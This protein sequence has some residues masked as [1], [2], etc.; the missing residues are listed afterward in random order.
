MKGT[1]VL[2]DGALWPTDEKTRDILAKFNRGQILIIEVNKDRNPQYHRLAF[3]RLRILY[4]MVDTDLEFNPWRRWLTVQAGYYTS[5]GK[6]NLQGVTS[7]AL[8]PDSLAFHKMDEQSF[9]ECWRGLHRAF[10]AEYGDSLS[11]DELCEWAAM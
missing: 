1:F 6:V 10:N 7:V 4:E 11:Y 9:T 3:A 2:R 8:K 5:L